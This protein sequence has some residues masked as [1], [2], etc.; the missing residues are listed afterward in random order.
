[1]MITCDD[2]HALSG[3]VCSAQCPAFQDVRETKYV[4]RCV[5]CVCGCVRRG[6]V[7][8]SHRSPPKYTRVSTAY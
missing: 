4:T 1:M 6:L 8:S 2:Q 3:P 7:V 5:M